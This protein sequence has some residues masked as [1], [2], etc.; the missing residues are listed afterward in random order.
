MNEKKAV[1]EKA[2]EFVKEGMVVGLGT[3]STVYYT[4]QLLGK[5]VQQGFSIKGIPTSR[6]TE[7]LANELNI[8]LTSFDDINQV[9]IAIDGADEV[10]SNLDL[11]KGGGGALLREKIVAKAAR[12]LI[13]VAD[14]SKLADQLGSFPLPVEIVPFGLEATRRHIQKLGIHPELR[15]VNGTPFITDNG[16]YILDCACRRIIAPHE[17]ENNL[18]IIPGVVDN[19]LFIG[20]ADLVITVDENKEVIMKKREQ[21]ASDDILQ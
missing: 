9:D 14:S 8:P 10:S 1:G 2:A 11:I 4:L 12:K 18:N 15:M 6:Q 5:L 20:M 21:K 16:N 7:K 3:G 17:L 19:G 13:I